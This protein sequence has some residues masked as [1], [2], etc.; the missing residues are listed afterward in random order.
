MYNH[1]NTAVE[2]TN[3]APGGSGLTA[4]TAGGENVLSGTTVSIP[5]AS[6][7]HY[8]VIKLGTISTANCYPVKLTNNDIA[9]VEVP[10]TSL[11]SVTWDNVSNKPSWIGSSKPSYTAS[12]VDALPS[13]TTWGLSI[14]GNNL[15]IS[16]GS[17]ST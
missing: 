4:A 11:T 10:A 14:S 6:S 16:K 2:W 15:S 13:S 8:G 3:V 1:N 17:G 12:E 5:K 9:Y 7:N